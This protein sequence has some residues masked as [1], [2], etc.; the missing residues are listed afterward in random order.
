M[1]NIYNFASILDCDDNDIKFAYSLAWSLPQ[2]DFS[3]RRGLN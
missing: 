3:E 2:K 1:K